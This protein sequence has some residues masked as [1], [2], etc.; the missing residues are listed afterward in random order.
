M[1]ESN[2]K[3]ILNQISECSLSVD[4]PLRGGITA[5]K[6]GTAFSVSERTFLTA[7]H[8][9]SEADTR[10]PLV[11]RHPE[12]GQITAQM[13]AKKKDEDIAVL[14]ILGS[15]VMQSYLDVSAE[16]PEAG[17]PCFWGGYPKFPGE[18]SQLLLIC[19]KGMVASEPYGPENGSFFQIDGNFSP[20]HSGSAIMDLDSGKVVGLVSRSAGDPKEIF[21]KNKMYIESLKTILQ[22]IHIFSISQEFNY[23][24]LTIPQIRAMLQR[25]GLQPVEIEQQDKSVRYVLRWGNILSSALQL[26]VA[27]A[28]IAQQGVEETYQM[29]VGVATGGIPLVESSALGFS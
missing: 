4:V 5:Y 7:Y 25:G 20:S 18:V 23:S 10:R 19:A 14:K 26:V 27:I 13:I 1:R 2:L 22:H 28:D 8:V 29:G 24:G 12:K 11:L 21:V 6:N 17:S 15:Q 3:R 9:V 16:I